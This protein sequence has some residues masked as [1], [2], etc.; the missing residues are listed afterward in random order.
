MKK[1]LFI[2]GKIYPGKNISDFEA[3][4]VKDGFIECTGKTKDLLNRFSDYEII[5]LNNC[6]ILPGFIDSHMH[7]TAYCLKQEQVDLFSE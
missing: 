1:K 5:D 6:R 2:N 4:A 7:F 3:I